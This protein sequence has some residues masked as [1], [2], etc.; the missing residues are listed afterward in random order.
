MPST[1]KSVDNPANLVNPAGFMDKQTVE[2][3]YDNRI[4]N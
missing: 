4:N 1:E 3:L 2:R